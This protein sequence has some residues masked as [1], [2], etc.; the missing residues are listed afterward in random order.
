MP[1]E[2]GVLEG[3]PAVFVALEAGVEDPGALELVAVLLEPAAGGGGVEGLEGID[4]FVPV[5]VA[6]EAGFEELEAAGVELL[7]VTGFAFGVADLEPVDAAGVPA[8][9][10]DFPEAFAVDDPVDDLPGLDLPDEDLFDEPE[11]V[12][13]ALGAV[14]CA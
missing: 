12:E 2:G 6:E 14:L 11:L 4:G 7:P 13:E 3:E 5:A 8:L 1:G 9:P 10:A